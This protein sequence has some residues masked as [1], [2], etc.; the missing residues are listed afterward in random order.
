MKLQFKYLSFFNKI[1]D[2][3]NV[4]KVLKYPILIVG[5]LLSLVT[6]TVLFILSPI[7]RIKIGGLIGQRIGHLA[8]NTELYFRQKK[9]NAESMKKTTPIFIVGRVANRQLINMW[10]RHAI[11]IESRTLRAL[12]ESSLKFWERTG[13]YEPLE[14]L[15]TEYYE[16]NATEPTL[17]F[18]QDEEI[19]GKAILKS[20]GINLDKNWYVC[21]YARDSN[22][23][24]TKFGF[25]QDW[26][27]H[28]YRNADI[29]TYKLAIDYIVS[30][31][32][33]VIRV[34]QH[35]NKALNYEHT[36][37]I[38]Y[39]LTQR[40][41]FMDIFLIANC[42]FFLGS[43]AGIGDVS[44]IFNRPQLCVN[45]APPTRPPMG[46]GSMFIPKKLREIKSKQFVKYKDFFEASKNNIRLEYFGQAVISK[47]WEY[48]DN[49]AQEILDATIEM[50]QQLDGF[51]EPTKEDVELLQKYYDW[52]PE[53]HW[54]KSYRIPIA[55]SFV[56]QNLNLYFDKKP[57]L[58]VITEEV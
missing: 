47:G 44:T 25:Q 21:I 8:L 24:K 58:S 45:A 33:F 6:W 32:G 27:Y 53:D 5:F 2:K 13:F 11:I 56:R 49:S 4:R 46:K 34:G 51:V 26:S 22:Y 37:V 1:L 20:M 41:D 19:K 42:R 3:S 28:D 40:T 35:V 15:S 9:L 23:L 57:I 50:I 29:D 39:S 52:I 55:V 14:M 54:S 31:G 7:I 16:F 10:K 17:K 43:P 18:T 36:Q 30:L 12:F 48:V 38:D